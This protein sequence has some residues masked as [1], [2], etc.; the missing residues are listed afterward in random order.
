LDDERIFCFFTKTGTG[1]F[2]YPNVI[3]SMEI[4]AKARRLFAREALYQDGLSCSS[5]HRVIAI[6]RSLL[7]IFSG[8]TSN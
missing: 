8:M 2:V 3:Y 4:D 7:I 5:Y 1:E 6:I